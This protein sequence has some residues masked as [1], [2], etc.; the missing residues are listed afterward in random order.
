[1]TQFKSE[2]LRKVPKTSSLC[3]RN[4]LLRASYTSHILVVNV[5]VFSRCYAI[6]LLFDIDSLSHNRIVKLIEKVLTLTG[7]LAIFHSAFLEFFDSHI[8]RA[9][10]FWKIYDAKVSISFVRLCSQ[11]FRLNKMPEFFWRIPCSTIRRKMHEK[12][13]DIKF[14]CV[15]IATIFHVRCNFSL[16]HARLSEHTLIRAVARDTLVFLLLFNH[17]L[18]QKLTKSIAN[19]NFATPPLIADLF[20]FAVTY[21]PLDVL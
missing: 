9:K 19:S 5:Q 11:R 8:K 14:D 10:C 2:N 13:Y 3:R 6:Q 20:I 21:R 18:C 12:V 1:M 4:K 16:L 17:I 7:V 15:L